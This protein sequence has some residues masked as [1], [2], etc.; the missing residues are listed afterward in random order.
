VPLLPVPG[1]LRWARRVLKKVSLA[2]ELNVL[3]RAVEGVIDLLDVGTFEYAP[4]RRRRAA[5]ALVL[6]AER[7]RL[8]RRTVVGAVDPVRSS[9]IT[10]RRTGGEATIPTSS[11]S[12]SPQRPQLPPQGKP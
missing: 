11:S 5:A 9:A 10:T 8:L 12:P 1:R 2:A 7:V 6:V 4:D 3:R